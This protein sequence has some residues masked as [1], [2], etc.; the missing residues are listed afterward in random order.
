MFVGS[1]PISNGLT[2]ACQHLLERAAWLGVGD[3]ER[4][5]VGADDAE[6]LE[7]QIDAAELGVVQA[8]DIPG[9]WPDLVSRH[10]F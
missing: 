3:D 7:S 9:L 4:L 6:L 10:S 2:E 8:S 5:P 1:C